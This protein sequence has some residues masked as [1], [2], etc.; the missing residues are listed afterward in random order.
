MQNTF[1]PHVLI[2]SSRQS[3]CGLTRA[4]GRAI[5][6]QNRDSGE[7]VEVALKDKKLNGAEKVEEGLAA[8]VRGRL[9]NGLLPC[10]GAF[11]LAEELALPRA[12]VGRAADVLEVHLTTCQ[13]GLF[14][15]PGK[16]KYWETTARTE[17]IVHGALEEA[18]LATRDKTNIISCEALLA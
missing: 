18:V 11:N 2:R 10:A 8:A 7:E 14:G 6:G 16:S 15:Y 3:R 4:Q 9:K 5:F 1:S 17:Q 13:L 12:E